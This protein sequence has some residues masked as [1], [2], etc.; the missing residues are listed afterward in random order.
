MR[1]LELVP[2]V[3]LTKTGREQIGPGM[4][5]KFAHLEFHLSPL[6]PSQKKD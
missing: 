2:I 6:E 1:H 4:R 3:Q 5:F